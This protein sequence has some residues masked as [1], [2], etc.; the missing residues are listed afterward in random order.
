MFA[1]THS[2]DC[3][4]AFSLVAR[5]KTDIEGILIQMGK[6]IR[7]SNYGQVIPSILNEEELATFIKSQL[8]VR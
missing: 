3:V 8:E 7:K 1:T 2:Y 6:S 5:D 4:K